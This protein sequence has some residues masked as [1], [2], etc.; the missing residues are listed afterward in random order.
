LSN[1][2][3]YCLHHPLRDGTI[4]TL[5]SLYR[6][7]YWRNYRR[8]FLTR[9]LLQ[10]R[11]HIRPRRHR[12]IPVADILALLLP[13]LQQNILPLFVVREVV[14]DDLPP[15]GLV[16]A[17]RRAVFTDFRR[18]EKAMAFPPGVRVCGS[19]FQIKAQGKFALLGFLNDVHGAGK[20]AVG[21]V[22]VGVDN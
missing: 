17:F 5:C 4:A 13:V 2:C 8:I 21:T 18:A 7:G 10:R 15:G 19:F 20:S 11:A 22:F 3:R 9:H 14:T 12:V 1:Y 16:M 6:G